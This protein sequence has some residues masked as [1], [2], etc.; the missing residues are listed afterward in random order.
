MST[1]KP[2]Q[3][4]KTRG[5]GGG[6]KAGIRTVD[7]RSHVVRHAL[8]LYSCNGGGVVVVFSFHIDKK[9]STKRPSYVVENGW[10]API[11]PNVLWGGGGYDKTQQNGNIDF[12]GSA[13]PASPIA[14]GPAH[15]S[16]CLPPSPQNTQKRPKTGKSYEEMCAILLPED[17][18]PDQRAKQPPLLLLA[19]RP[20]TCFQ[21]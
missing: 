18:L 6:G 19:V 14:S 4:K 12:A 2:P 11:A 3:K 20:G 8:S 17:I 7:T 5:E 16:F 15:E 13:A 10:E 21:E 1:R 9:E